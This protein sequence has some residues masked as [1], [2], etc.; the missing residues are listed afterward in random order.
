MA[1][2]LVKSKE[3]TVVEFVD[4]TLREGEQLFSSILD[5]V[6]KEVFNKTKDSEDALMNTISDFERKVANIPESMRLIWAR[7]APLNTTETDQNKDDLADIKKKLQDFEDKVKEETEKEKDLPL[8]LRNQMIKFIT[9]SRGIMNEIGTEDEKMWS[10]LKLMEKEMFQF[11]LT[12]AEA[13]AELKD[14]LNSLFDALKK[15]GLP[16]LKSVSDGGQFKSFINKLLY[17]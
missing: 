9:A 10:K 8:A 16:K 3:K 1:S 5:E 11:Q 17:E 14:N 2:E 13:S 6:T 12:F 4:N 15:V 7:N